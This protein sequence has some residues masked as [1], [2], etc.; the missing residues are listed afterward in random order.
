VG[1]GDGL[2]VSDSADPARWIEVRLAD[3]YAPEL[4]APGGQDAKRALIRIAMGRQVTCTAGKRSY[5]RVVARCW[6]GPTSIGDLMRRAGVSE[7]GN[8]R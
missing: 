1:D 7:G 5:D 2:C 3:F 6:V 4:Q 8:G